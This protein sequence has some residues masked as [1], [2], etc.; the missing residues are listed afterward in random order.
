MTADPDPSVAGRLSSCPIL[1][2]TKD[3]RTASPRVV[4]A[5]RRAQATGAEIRS[6]LPRDSRAGPVSF[7]CLQGHLS[8][9]GLGR[10]GRRRGCRA[11]LLGSPGLH[12]GPVCPWCCPA[13][14]AAGDASVRGAGVGALGSLVPAAQARGWQHAAA[15]AT[16]AATSSALQDFP[17]PPRGPLSSPLRGHPSTSAGR[18]QE[19]WLL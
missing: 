18:S 14:A 1:W 9:P 3:G 12:A 2:R 7:L 17:R 4:T 8:L 10:Q 5:R 6:K 11:S 13:C 19:P 16:S 15:R